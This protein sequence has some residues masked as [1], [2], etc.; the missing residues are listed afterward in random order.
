[1][2]TKPHEQLI[3]DAVIK[4]MK[5]KFGFDAKIV[6]KKKNNLELLGD[7]SLN[8]T[9]LNENKFYLYFTDQ[10]FPMMIKALIHELTHI[11][12]IANGEL[13]PSSDYKDLLWHDK[14]IMSVKDYKRLGKIDHNKY[15]ETPW[16]KEAW[17]NM[18]N[19]YQPFLNSS[20]WKDLKGKD[21]I[22]DF[23]IDTW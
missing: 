13:K 16:E 10:S 9:A 3:A 8:S 5:S 2:K 19:L 18:S 20:F 6:L 7:V 11:K 4:F 17:R 1:M 23:I 22:L 15:K 21:R 14:K 12:Q